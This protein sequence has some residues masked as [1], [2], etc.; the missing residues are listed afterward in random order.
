[1]IQLHNMDCMEYMKGLDDNAFDICVTSPPYNMNLRINSR[2]DGYCSRQIKKEISTKYS[3]YDDNMPMD[4]YE[5]F[6]IDVMTNILRVS[7]IC[8]FNIQMITGNKPALFRFMGHFAD[9]IKEMIVWDKTRAQPAIRDG[10]LNSAYEVI[11]VMG[12]NPISRRFDG[13][14]FPRGTLDNIF[15][16]PTQPGKIDDHRATF[17]IHLTDKI[18]KNFSFPGQSVFD[19]FL[20][21]GTTAI[22]AHYAGLNFT[23]C[24]VNPGYFNSAKERIERETSQIDMF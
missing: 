21:S 16:V 23:G 14:P 3:G 15:R 9:H 11:L 13:A 19:P 22:S 5:S 7:K 6:L 4:D 24:E 20:G 12:D 2:G 10:C 8:F 18:L 17:P 1:M